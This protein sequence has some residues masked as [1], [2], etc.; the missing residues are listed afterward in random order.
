[1][2][3]RPCGRIHLYLHLPAFYAY[4]YTYFDAQTFTDA[5]IRANASASPYAATA[6]VIYVDEEETQPSICFLSSARFNRTASLRI[7]MF[8]RG[9][10]SAGF[11]AS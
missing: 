1:M 9:G 10:N 2:R 11:P 3:A 4:T 6:P 7:G 8:Y 5:E